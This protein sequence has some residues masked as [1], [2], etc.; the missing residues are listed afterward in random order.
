ML[1]HCYLQSCA[2]DEEELEKTG[3]FL[4]RREVEREQSNRATVKYSERWIFKLKPVRVRVAII[5]A[6][7]NLRKL[8]RSINEKKKNNCFF[9]EQ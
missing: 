4:I 1:E 5:S 9:Y 3:E 8:I 6:K 2:H 7:L